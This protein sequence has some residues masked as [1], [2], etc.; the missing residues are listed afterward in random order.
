MQCKSV[1]SMT[2]GNAGGL[3]SMNPGAFGDISENREY[4]LVVL[5][6]RDKRPGRRVLYVN[7]Y[8]GAS[9]WAKVASGAMPPQHLWGCLE[10]VRMGYEVGLTEPLTHFNLRRRPLP[11]DLVYVRAVRDWLGADGI[12]Y[13]A[14]TL[15][16]WLPLLRRVG[17]IKAPIVSL[18]Y[19]RE[20]L[21]WARLHSGIIAMTPAAVDQAQEMA[22]KVKCLH[23]G[24]G[25]D[26]NYFPRLDYNPQ[27]LLSCGITRRDF[28]TLSAAAAKVKHPIQVVC[29]G[30]PEGI[31][32]PENVNATNSGHGYNFEIKSVSFKDLLL[33]YYGKCSALLVIIQED[34]REYTANGF[35]NVL[36][37]M[38][39]GRPIIMTRTG[40]VPGEID[41]EKHGCGLFVPPRDPAALAEA[42]EAVSN[43]T[44]GAEAMGVAGRRLCEKHYNMER[45]GADLD[46]FFSG[47]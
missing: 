21:D 12:I 5:R 7:S 33:D 28:Q 6:A 20:E 30:I 32:W 26:L 39:M 38:A 40:A 17:R 36:E 4:G 1:D 22:P 19:A 45:F 44:K 18:T 11:H 42:M 16:Y 41:I 25:V 37:G 15:L 29:P 46:R 14:H 34:Q 23:A 2:P 43:D 27:A 31:T 24:W 10:L 3:T 8:G 47:L 13:S 9:L 35:T